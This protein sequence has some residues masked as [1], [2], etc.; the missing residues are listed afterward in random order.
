[1]VLAG[2]EVKAIRKGMASLR[3]A[4]V[5]ID[6]YEAWLKGATVT[7]YQQANTPTTYDPVRPRKLLL[8]KKELT[9]L[10]RRAKEPGLTIIP[11][12]L[13]NAGRHLKLAIGVARGKK[14]YDKRQTLKAREATREMG[15][16]LKEQ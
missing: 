8:S 2:H 5:I 15:R 6:G 1:L 7:P 16:F 10:A 4:Y 9:E 11:L 13:Y 12:R 3:G 14:Q